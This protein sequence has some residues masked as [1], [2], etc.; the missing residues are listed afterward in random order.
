[1][2]DEQEKGGRFSRWSKRKLA[3]AGA[4]TEPPATQ[5]ALAEAGSDDEQLEARAALLE[6]NKQAAEAVDIEALDAES[7]FTIFLKEG[8][9]E[10]LKKQAMLALWRSNPVLANVDGLVD[11][12]DD[13]ASPDLIMKTFKSAYQVGK[14]YFDDLDEE[15]E[16]DAPADDAVDIAADD[17]ADGAVEDDVEQVEDDG[18][19]EDMHMSES[20]AVP[21]E[22]VADVAENAAVEAEEPSDSVA[23]DEIEAEDQM[24]TARVSLR[25]RFELDA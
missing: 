5:D 12:D 15:G 4:E 16:G 1:M 2:D 19:E 8:V 17:G 6:A 7:D 3:S 18:A 14:G 21:D 23:A 25:Q 10:L 20:D 13:F 22:P 11:Y 24:P 9:P